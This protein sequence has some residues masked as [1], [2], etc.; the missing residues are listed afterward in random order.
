MIQISPQQKLMLKVEPIDFRK[1]MDSLIGVC[2]TLISDP[3][4]GAIFAF[5]NKRG[6]SVK[7]L[8]YD[9]TGFWLCAKRFSKGKL[10]YWPRSIQDNICATTMMIIL[11]QGTPVVM[12]ASWRQLPGSASVSPYSSK[13]TNNQ[14]PL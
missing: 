14:D 9:G 3:Y 12:A 11:N 2:L 5:R 10:K 13:A 4:Q 7:L 8:A 6:T 1:G